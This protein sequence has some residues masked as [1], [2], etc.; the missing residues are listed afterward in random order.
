MRKKN[1]VNLLHLK[2]GRYVIEVVY[3]VATPS[4]QTAN[5]KEAEL[6]LG[7]NNLG[8]VVFN[9]KSISSYVVVI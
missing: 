3:E 4:F 7:V 8:T 5:Q 2:Y 9:R 6:D 1:R